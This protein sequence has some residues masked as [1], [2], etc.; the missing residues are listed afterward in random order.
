MSTKTTYTNVM[1]GFKQAIIKRGLKLEGSLNNNSTEKEI[2]KKKQETGLP[3]QCSSSGKKSDK[4]PKESSPLPRSKEDE[5][6]YV[7]VAKLKENSGYPLITR[8]PSSQ[9]SRSIKSLAKDHHI[10]TPEPKK[11]T[12][13]QM[14][15]KEYPVSYPGQTAHQASP[16]DTTMTVDL[17]LIDDILARLNLP[18][19]AGTIKSII[20]TCTSWILSSQYVSTANTGQIHL[21]S[22]GAG[23]GVCM[24]L[25]LMYPYLQVYIGQ[26][27][28]LFIT[29]FRHLIIWIIA[30]VFLSYVMN[31]KSNT[32]TR[33]PRPQPP[34][35]HRYTELEYSVKSS[36]NTTRSASP[37]KQNRR[38]S[39]PRRGTE[40]VLGPNSRRG[41]NF[42]DAQMLISMTEHQQFM[43]RAKLDAALEEDHRDGYDR[44]MS[45]ALR[46]EGKRENYNN[47]VDGAALNEEEKER[48]KK[49]VGAT[50]D[51]IMKKRGD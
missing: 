36:A 32:N 4:K 24:V 33:E 7:H 51:Q 1:T 23:I 2:P 40:P 13:S 35:E 15:S 48:Y 9:S 10:Y 45:G 39:L 28:G 30:G 43:E 14:A 29:I 37:T 16:R 50:R 46:E 41:S 26:W 3:A 44:F 5:E 21:Q 6:I 25:A 47:F 8:K 27:L 34:L 38:R 12:Y 17:G 11:A 31:P 42:S 20:N 18:A 19:A 22:F 49:F